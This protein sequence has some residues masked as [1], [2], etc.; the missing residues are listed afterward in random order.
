MD[1]IL[2]SL[3]ITVK[4]RYM[5]NN[6]RMRQFQ[7]LAGLVVSELSYIPTINVLRNCH[8]PVNVFFPFL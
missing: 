4:S 2:P 5:Y 8:I 7:T 1:L 6:L 3:F